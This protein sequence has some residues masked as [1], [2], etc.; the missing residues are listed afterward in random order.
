MP[1]DETIAGGGG[2]LGDVDKNIDRP[3]CAM[4]VASGK[5]YHFALF[6]VT[7]T[8]ISARIV[9]RDGKLQDQFEK[10]LP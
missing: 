9:D 10:A 8:G 3:E 2:L 7:K 6:D 1:F 4:R 5:F